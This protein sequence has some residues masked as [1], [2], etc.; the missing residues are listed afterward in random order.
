MRAA[1]KTK[2][3]ENR[4]AAISKSRRGEGKTRRMNGV[5]SREEEGIVGRKSGEGEVRRKI[6]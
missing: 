1:M 5:R 2:P 4:R 6:C 3:I